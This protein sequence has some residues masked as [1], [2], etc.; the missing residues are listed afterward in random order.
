LKG[1]RDKDSQG[2]CKKGVGVY[3]LTRYGPARQGAA[4][5]QSEKSSARV[6]EDRLNES[7][8]P[9]ACGHAQRGA[10]RGV[11]SEGD[12]SHLLRAIAA[13]RRSNA[14][15]RSA[16]ACVRAVSG[17]GCPAVWPSIVNKYANSVRIPINNISICRS[18]SSGRCGVDLLTI[19]VALPGK[20]VAK[21]LGFREEQCKATGHPRTLGFF[22]CGREHWDVTRRRVVLV[23]VATVGH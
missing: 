11:Q 6:L 23:T 2:R 14:V 13:R 10:E 7:H 22:D 9:V 15:C 1:V 17:G 20:R 8:G 18:E 4:S 5:R 3:I 21:G 16:A 12:G 19:Q